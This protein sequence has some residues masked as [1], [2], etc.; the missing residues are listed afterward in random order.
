MP[1]THSA[2]R[3][4]STGAITTADQVLSSAS[5]ALMV[6]AVAQVSPAEQFGIVALLVTVATTWIGFNRGALGTA[7]LL[8]SNMHRREISAEGGY[9]TSWSLLTSVVAGAVLLVL[10]GVFG[11]IWIGV[12]FAVSLVAVLA[13]DVLRFVA[14]AQGRPLAAAVCDGFWVVWILTVYLIN[15]ITS[16]MSAVITVYLWGVGGLISAVVLMRVLQTRPRGHRLVGWWRTYDRARLRF[17]IVY[18]LNQV[19]ATLVTLTVTVVVSGTAAAGLRGAATLFGPIAMLVSALPLVFVPHVRRAAS[20]I[21]EQW[22]VL[23]KTSIATSGLTVVAGLCLA[24]IPGRLGSAI[25]GDTWTYASALVIYLGIECAA[26]CWMVSVYSFFQARG[27]S[28]TVLQVKLF[29][30]SLQLVLCLCAGLAVGTAVAI[31]ISLAVAGVLAAVVGVVL[32]RRVVWHGATEA[33]P[34]DQDSAAQLHKPLEKNGFAWPMID[35]LEAEMG[36]RRSDV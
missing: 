18:A 7:L 22:Q 11:Q 29:Q 35:V 25:L 1:S 32:A 36:G 10:S 23:V 13:Q 24:L 5:N 4:R 21:G 26:M 17:G 3:A 30:I 2:S 34:A 27:M 6:F 19:G 8:T 15:L 20:S 28:R 33:P 31:A 9:A 16:G 12:A 14:I